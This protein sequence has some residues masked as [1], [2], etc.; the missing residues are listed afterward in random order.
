MANILF[1]PLLLFLFSCNPIDQS[2]RIYGTWEGSYMGKRNTFSFKNNNTCNFDVFDQQN[3]LIGT[4]S[5]EFSLDFSK[6][7][8]LLS[9]KKIPQLDHP[10]YSIIE[11]IGEDSLNIAD[12]SPKWRLRPIAFDKEKTIS[13]KYHSK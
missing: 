5:G 10:L 8:I 7:P 13:L 2:D 11:F 4:V 12:F 1:I 6:K 3:Q 9:I